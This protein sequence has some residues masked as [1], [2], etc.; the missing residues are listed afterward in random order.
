MTVLEA[1]KHFF[2]ESSEP[3]LFAGAGVSAHAGI[4][5]WR[6]L[7]E[8]LKE[9]IRSRDALTANMMEECIHDHDLIRAADYFFL[10]RKVSDGNRYDALKLNLS[11]YDT[12]KLST[13]MKLPFEGYITTN[14]DRCLLDAY[15]KQRGT[16]LLDYKLGDESFKQTQWS[17]SPFLSRIHGGIENPKSMILTQ[18][19]FDSLSENDV[20]KDLLTFIFTRKNVLFTGFS[21]LDPAI[22]E[23]LTRVNKIYGPL[24]KGRHIALLPSS[25]ESDFLSKLN[26]LN[27]ESVYYSDCDHHKEL[28]VAIEEY[29]NDVLEK[30]STPITPIEEPSHSAFDTAKRYLASC[31]ARSRMGANIA[32]LREIVAIGIVSTIIQ[33]NAPKGMLERT[34][35]ETVKK[36]LGIHTNDATELVA[37]AVKELV[38]EKLIRRHNDAGK[39]KVA[40]INEPEQG[41]NSLNFA[42]E[43]LTSS[44]IDRSRVQEGVIIYPKMKEPIKKFFHE[45]FL[46]RGWD[47]GAAYAN[48]SL[49]KEIN[50]S[51]LLKQLCPEFS[52]TDHEKVTRACNS[53]L[54]A[55]TTEE[56]E[57]L[58]ELGNVSFALELII[59]SPRTTLLHSAALPQNVYLDANVLMP[60][61]TYGHPY[62]G[63][64]RETID[65]LKSA[66]SRAGIDL[67]IIAYYGYLNEIVSHRKLAIKI[68][69]E[70]GQDYREGIFREALYYGTKNMN[71][72][73]GSYANALQANEKL[74]F[75][76]FLTKYAPYTSEEE[77]A[78]WLKKLGIQVLLDKEMRTKKYSDVSYELQKAYAEGLVSG[79]LIRLIE[80]DAVQI[81]RIIADREKGHRSIFVTA[82]K[83]LKELLSHGKYKTVTENMIS[84]IALTQMIE[85][86]VGNIQEKRGLSSLL[87]SYKTATKYDEIRQ[88]LVKAALKEY[89]QAIAMEMPDVIDQIT[90]K[91]V[92]ELQK[93]KLFPDSDDPKE[94]QRYLRE[95]GEFENMFFQ[96]LRQ[97][98]EQ[99]EKSEQDI[100]H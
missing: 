4:K 16:A 50:V 6:P 60:A 38:S 80:H 90:E 56:A 79:K 61:L 71:V 92:L 46:Q 76:Q 99:R 9:W 29:V 24:T 100:K 2:T 22:K 72:F 93:H 36:E 86:F 28:W 69:E 57:I 91:A 94:K 27:I 40:W 45:L 73:V 83:Q 31:Y 7:L 39:Q 70:W 48:N 47:L 85:L 12:S 58:S 67:K 33:K 17:D 63:V 3:I 13:L 19:H 96:S 64:Y 78:K 42:L 10:S 26:R 74:T 34:V 66:S 8:G 20:Y 53:L 52:Y 75:Q 81:S 1:L 98:I 49:P 54:A 41:Q 23:V 82:D 88:Y 55:P 68:V 62:Y 37:T 11:G 59:Q 65:K 21:F 87:W 44:L 89:D 5:T 84:N 15:S 97:K 30:K 25:I 51:S 32:S 77:L 35:I 14:F 95:V 43:N 18:A